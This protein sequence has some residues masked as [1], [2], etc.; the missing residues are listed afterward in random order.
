MLAAG[1][2]KKAGWSIDRHWRSIQRSPGVQGKPN[3]L[4]HEFLAEENSTN[5]AVSDDNSVNI[6][7]QLMT[8]GEILPV[9]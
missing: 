4:I 7:G 3:A 8:D 5:D 1:I 9:F 2:A 6:I